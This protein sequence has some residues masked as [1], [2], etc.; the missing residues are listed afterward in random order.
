MSFQLI[1]RKHSFRFGGAALLSLVLVASS[2]AEWRAVSGIDLEESYDSNISLSP[3]HEV[4]DFI[5]AVNVGVGLEEVSAT[6]TFDARYIASLVSFARDSSYNYI[7]HSADLGWEQQLSRTVSWHVR[8][9]FYLSE[10]PLEQDPEIDAVRRTRSRYYRNALDTGLTYQFG[11]DDRVFLSYA[12]GRLE[13]EDPE[14]EDSLTY[15]PVAGLE[16]WLT[17]SHGLTLG[18]TWAR[19]EYD[20]SPSNKNETAAIGYRW[21][22]S[23][24]T[25]LTADYRNGRFASADPAEE[26]YVVHEALAGFEHAPGPHWTLAGSLGYF[27]R[28]PEESAGDDGISYSLT[29]GRSFER[30]SVTLSGAGGYRQE[31]TG[32]ERRGFTEYRSV[33]LA[34]TYSLS[35]RAEIFGSGSYTHLDATD[36]G[37]S[38]YDVY[39]DIGDL[40]DEMW[41]V[42]AG[43]SYQILPWLAGS[44]EVA[45]RERWSSDPESEYRD[46]LVLARLRAEYEWR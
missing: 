30:G 29:L 44:V 3:D 7:G 6:R 40:R 8:D 20:E 43:A 46:T 27:Y 39:R 41:S 28:D 11:E 42:S 45:Q 12:D 5:N 38:L 32:A 17:R 22:W 13:N 23:P 33:S 35:Q 14:V 26:D 9:G 25:T 1:E 2:W 18:Y 15:G 31:Y 4:S 16:Y 37:S 10:E 34:C 24:R 36:A 21:R 19:T